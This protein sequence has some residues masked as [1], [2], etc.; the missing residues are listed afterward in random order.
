MP[1]NTLNHFKNLGNEY[2]SGNRWNN[3]NVGASDRHCL[4]SR[5]SGIRVLTFFIFLYDVIFSVEHD[6]STF[7]AFKTGHK[8][9]NSEKPVFGYFEGHFEPPS[10]QKKFFRDFHLFRLH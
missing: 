3:L 9:E 10:G 5:Q 1:R 2:F 6:K 7:T 4:A 8:F